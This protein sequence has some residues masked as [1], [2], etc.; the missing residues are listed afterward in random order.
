MHNPNNLI[1]TVPKNRWINLGWKN[2]CK[3]CGN[4]YHLKRHSVDH[5]VANHGSF[6]EVIYEKSHG[7]YEHTYETNIDWTNFPFLTLLH[8]WFLS[9]CRHISF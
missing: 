3:N 5:D 6:K 9:N 1:L 7:N 2:N 4:Y 8:C